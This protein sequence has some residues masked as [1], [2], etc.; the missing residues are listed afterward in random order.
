LIVLFCV[1]N[2]WLAKDPF[3]RFKMSKEEVI[4]EVLTKEEYL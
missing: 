2:N 3:A 4:P 1:N